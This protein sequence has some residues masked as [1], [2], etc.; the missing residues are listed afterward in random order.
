MKSYDI[1]PQL[2]ILKPLR[3]QKYTD[4]RRRLMNGVNCFA[5]FISRPIFNVERKKI[6][7][8]SYRQGKFK[9]EFLKL[10]DQIEK[11]PCILFLHGG[12]FQMEATPIH[13]KMVT[14][15]MVGTRYHALYV[16]YRLA[17]KHPFPTSLEDAYHALL[18]LE[19][20]KEKLKI[21]DIIVA[22]DS[23]GGNLATALT[24]LSRD[25]NGPQI[26]K[27]LLLYP[28]IDHRQTTKTMKSYVDTPMW[29]AVLNKSMWELYLRDGHHDMLPYASPNLADL[30]DL[31]EAYIETA[32]YDCLRDEGIMYA[33][34]L[35]AAGVKVT[36][37]HTKRT[38][39]GYDACFLSDL[40]KNLY[41]DRIRFLRGE[42]IHEEN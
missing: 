25:R 32:E 34:Q 30:H 27:Q 12:G 37:N 29:N 39:H 20:N 28:V 15:M 2:K 42:P 40:V 36:E 16:H 23:A 26:T 3:F 1:D 21:S 9:A 38:V 35:K 14:T 6:I 13:L 5:N 4:G 22:G 17:P 11:T 10:R 8:E 33:K 18:W 41:N 19:T 7:I 24:L 31:P